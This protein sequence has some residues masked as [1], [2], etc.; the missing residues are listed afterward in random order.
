MRK[1]DL[2]WKNA[3]REKDNFTCQRCGLYDKYI[4]T[5]HVASRARRPDLRHDITNGICLDAICHMWVHHHP[6]EAEKLGL[7]SGAKY[8]KD[9]LRERF[10]NISKSLTKS[11]D[12][13][14]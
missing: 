9:R 13:P 1:A 10:G 7:L 5:H 3:V 6:A 4:H 2:D 11:I 12:S 14:T 8:E